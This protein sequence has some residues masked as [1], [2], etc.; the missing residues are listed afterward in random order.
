MLRSYTPTLVSRA[1]F[2]ER[3]RRN[4]LADA[5]GVSYWVILR[6]L[7]RTAPKLLPKQQQPSLS[8]AQADEARALLAAGW[9]LR[10]VGRRFGVSYSAIWRLIQRARAGNPTQ[11]SEGT[12]EGDETG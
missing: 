7:R 12:K 4:T 8:E 10:K 11:Q 5:F 6:L 2:V 9:S 3:W 1:R